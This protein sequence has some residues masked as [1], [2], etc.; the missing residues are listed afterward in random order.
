MK[1]S[2]TRALDLIT[3]RYKIP[4]PLWWRIRQH[5]RRT[6]VTMRSACIDLLELG[7][8]HPDSSESEEE[9]ASEE[10]A[11]DGG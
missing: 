4:L 9:R 10:A 11:D 6:S 1:L 7:L 8:S 2:A 3:I 5:S